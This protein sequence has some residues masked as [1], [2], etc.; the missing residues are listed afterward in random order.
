ML[1]R[2]KL[3]DSDQDA[4]IATLI[5]HQSKPEITGVTMETLALLQQ[6]EELLK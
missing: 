3:R 4:Y 5:E 1:Y 2:V 6:E